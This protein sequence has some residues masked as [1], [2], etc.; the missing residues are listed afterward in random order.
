[1]TT[2]RNHRFKVQKSFSVN[3]KDSDTRFSFCAHLA[4]L[5]SHTDRHTDHATCDIG[6]TR[7]HLCTACIIIIAVTCMASLTGAQRRRTKILK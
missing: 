7:P 2:K 5:R 4:R 1:L 3:Q 6:S